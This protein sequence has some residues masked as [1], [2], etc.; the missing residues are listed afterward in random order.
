MQS[1]DLSTNVK[2]GEFIVT[3]YSE[4]ETELKNIIK[5][6]ENVIIS[7][8]QVQL[9]KK[10]KTRLNKLKKSIDDERKKAKKKILELYE[11]GENQC[12]VLI[13]IIDKGIENLDK[14]LKAIENGKREQIEEMWNSKKHDP[15][16]S[17][18]TILISK[19]LTD[20]CSIERVDYEMEKEIDRI[21]REISTITNICQNDSELAL[22]LNDYYKNT[23]LQMAI[24]SLTERRK[25]IDALE[26]KKEVE[27][28]EKA[29]IYRVGFVIR[30]SKRKI[31]NLANYLNSQSIKFTQLSKEE[32]ET[33][34][35]IKNQNKNEGE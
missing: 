17:L 15:H 13:G 26:V 8:D 20:S 22:T 27:E 14:Q 12:K 28:I 2:Q 9:A 11:P 23:N 6:Y 25:T 24:D 19:W 34:E 35:S 30:A 16:I 21:N 4:L 3:N 31:D 32:L 1:L 18:D 29:K 5:P 7:N 33:L 10:D